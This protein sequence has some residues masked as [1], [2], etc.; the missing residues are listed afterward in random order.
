M[1]YGTKFRLNRKINSKKAYDIYKSDL[2]I[3]INKISY[4]YN[5]PI[6]LFFE[7]RDAILFEFKLFVGK[8]LN[9]SMHTY[10]KFSFALKKQVDNLKLQY[11][12]C[13]VDKAA[14]NFAII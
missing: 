9:S 4:K 5:T 12:F 7:W 8:Y 10:H 13:P 6:Q 2:N 1:K 14:N 11:V 3:F